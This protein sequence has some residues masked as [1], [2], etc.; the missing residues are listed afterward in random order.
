MIYVCDDSGLRQ[1]DIFTFPAGEVGVKLVETTRQQNNFRGYTKIFCEMHNANDIVGLGLVLQKIPAYQYTRLYIPYLPYG[2]NDK[3][4]DSFGFGIK[5]F[6]DILNAI[7]KNVNEIHTYTPHSD[8][9]EALVDKLSVHEYKPYIHPDK[10]IIAPDQGAYKRLYRMYPDHNIISFSKV[11]DSL[12]GSGSIISLKLDTDPS[13]I[14]GEEFAVVDD[15]CDGGAT[16]INVA[17]KLHDSLG[18]R[19]KRLELYVTHGIFSKGF[20]ELLKHYDYIQYCNTYKFNDQPSYDCVKINDI[21]SVITG[22]Q[23]R[24]I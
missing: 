3:P 12:S 18:D 23:E 16:F 4:H 15:L 22:S 10:T 2:R 17:Q 19:V 6:S 11:R 9:A 14:Q 21:V 24:I 1:F 13:L 8:M 5:I 7:A 20:D